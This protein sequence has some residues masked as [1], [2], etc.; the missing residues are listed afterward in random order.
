MAGT[1]LTPPLRR[2]AI[3][4]VALALVAAISPGLAL[5]ANGPPRPFDDAVTTAEDTPTG[6]NVLTNDLNNGD[7]PLTVTG[8]GALA[9]SIG[10]L[11]VAAN[12]VFTFS[13]A[14]DWN[15]SVTTTYT[16]TNANGKSKAANLQITVT[17]AQDAPVANGDTVTIDEDTPTNVTAQVLANDTDVD[18]DTLSVSGFRI[19]PAAASTSRPASSPSRPPPTCAATTRAASTTP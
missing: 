6:G 19:P 9:P 10:T 1:H 17:A 16:A 13:P 14:A 11:N 18:G 15:G 7:D 8:F 3:L 4:L 2:L 5:A 12:G